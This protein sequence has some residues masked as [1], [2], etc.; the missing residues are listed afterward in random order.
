MT[1]AEL[2]TEYLR[3]A[4]LLKDRMQL[5]RRQLRESSDPEEQWQL[6][7]RIA[8]LTP[9]LTQMNELADLTAHYYEPGY[10]RNDKYTL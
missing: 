7:R 8:D 5:L 6:R 10:W 9:L 1:L 3:S 2:S 4:R